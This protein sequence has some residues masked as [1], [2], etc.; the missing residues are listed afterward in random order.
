MKKIIFLITLVLLGSVAFAQRGNGGARRSGASPARSSVSTPRSSST[1]VRNHVSSPRNTATYSPN[2][3]SYRQHSTTR[4]RTSSEFSRPNTRSSVSSGNRPSGV[5][6][7]PREANM[8]SNRGHGYV[9]PPADH[10]Q[11]HHPHHRPL[12]HGMHPMPP[13]YHP[14]HHRHMHMHH[15]IVSDWMIHNL[16]WHNY[17]MYVHTYPYNEVVIYVKGSQPSVDIIALECDDNYIYTIY[18][19]ELLNETYFTI[20][21]QNDNVLVKTE[22][23]K[24]YCKIVTD[25]NGVWLLKK[26]DKDPIYFIYQDGRLFKYEED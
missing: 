6:N 9:R 13:M 12:P 17:W 1:S 7:A 8:G 11:V 16:Y 24:R 23:N 19:D 20:S 5:R 21:D 14:I 15:C 3:Q 26:R 4:N 10:P 25:E 18:K 2:R 22:I